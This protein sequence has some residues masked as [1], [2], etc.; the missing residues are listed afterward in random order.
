[1]TIV[2][3]N[4]NK[5]GKAE[6]VNKK[7]PKSC[8]SALRLLSALCTDLRQDVSDDLGEAILPWYVQSNSDV[9]LTMN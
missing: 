4:I 8:P 9:I 3:V 2:R 6:L 5:I 7:K 1:M